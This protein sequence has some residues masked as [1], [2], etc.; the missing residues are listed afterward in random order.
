MDPLFA[1]LGLELA[2]GTIVNAGKAVAG[3]LLGWAKGDEVTRLFLEL[4]SRFGSTPGL[5]ASGLEPLRSDPVFIQLL[6]LF[7]STGSFPR[8]EMV[9]AIEPHL[10]ATRTQTPRDLAEQ[11]ADAID[12][13]SA[14]AR[15]SNQ[16]LF[17]IEALRQSVTAQL[18]VLRSEV[19]ATAMP[20]VR[21]IT[22]DWA[23]PLTRDRLE[24]MLADGAADLAPLEEELRGRADP[25]PII[26]GLILHPPAWLGAASRRTWEALGEIADGYGLW[27]EASAAFEHAAGQPGADRAM[28][29]ARAAANARLGG[30]A[31]RHKRL[32]DDARALDAGHAQVVL[33]D[34]MPARRPR[35]GSRYSTAHR[36][37]R[38]PA[39]KPRS[40]S[41]ARSLR[42]TA[43]TGSKPNRCSTPCVR[44]P[45]TTSG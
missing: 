20:S 43:E 2:A 38:I 19:R 30:D 21:H 16:E 10:G 31:D 17:A 34:S 44:M 39:A 12:L 45:R 23:P 32:L 28:L 27:R 9:Y 24:R 5:S 40:M 35:S 41:H 1:A 18:E 15:G 14:R 22:V 13:Y 8:T 3:A 6:A 33:A 42:W 11:I 4:D 25:R 7:W 36:S 26:R 29:L 37:K